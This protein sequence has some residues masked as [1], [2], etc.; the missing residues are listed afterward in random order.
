MS[1][2]R[3]PRPVQERLRRLLVIL[4]WLAERGEATLEEMTQRFQLSERELIADLEQVA[5]CGLPPFLDECIDLFIDDGVA[6]MG[7]PRFFT[8]PLRLTAPEG[9]ALLAAGRTALALPG[10]DTDGAL[11]RALDKLE[12]LLGS[13]GIVLDLAEPPATAALAA[14]AQGGERVRI[15]Y[16]SP[17]AGEPTE[18]VVTPRA[19]YTDWG[20]WYVIADDDR[21]GEERIFRIDRILHHEATGE[22]VALREVEVPMG[23]AWFDDL[24]EASGAVRATLE[25]EP[26]G[27]WLV[28]RYPVRVL[29]DA[30]PVWRVELAVSSERWLRD[31]LVQLGT[32]ARVVAPDAWTGLAAHAAAELLV[33][34]YAA[35]S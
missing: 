35:S 23:D 22:T 33:R 7:V 24:A 19:V 20:R 28:E 32:A 11:A 29:D 9:F 1:T 34:R 10:A 6:Y 13:D 17:S 25:L 31:L 15:T 30:T 26:S 12:Q 27:R 8:R 16:L 3:G 14:A 18:R 4:P 5:C 2:R 21:S